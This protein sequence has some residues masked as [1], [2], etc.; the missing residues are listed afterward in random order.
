M[1]GLPGLDQPDSTQLMMEYGSNQ[2]S[3]A[4]AAYRYVLPDAQGGQNA[5]DK[6]GNCAVPVLLWRSVTMEQAQASCESYSKI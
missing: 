2:E 1:Q 6:S 3:G 5:R 4:I